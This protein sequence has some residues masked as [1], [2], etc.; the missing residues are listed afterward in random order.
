MFYVGG[1]LILL[2][3]IWGAVLL[4][5]GVYAL[6]RKGHKRLTTIVIRVLGVLALI[7][8]FW[9]LVATTDRLI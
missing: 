2:E 5:L 6:T 9:E 7:W 1:L 3:Y 4:A 8:G